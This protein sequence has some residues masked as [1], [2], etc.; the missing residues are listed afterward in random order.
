MGKSYISQTETEHK[1]MINE[2]ER[3][4]FVS[5]KRGSTISSDIPKFK[6]ENFETVMAFR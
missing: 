1:Y 6:P 5:L 3:R 4:Y 2:E